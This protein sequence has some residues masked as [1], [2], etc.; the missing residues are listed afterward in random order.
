MLLEIAHVHANKRV[1]RDID[2]KRV[3]FGNRLNDTWREVQISDKVPG[4]DNVAELAS[5]LMLAVW[6]RITDSIVK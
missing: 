4:E 2:T 6:R 5:T 3:H 1:L